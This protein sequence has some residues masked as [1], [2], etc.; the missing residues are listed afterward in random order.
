MG[1]ALHIVT[2]AL[3]RISMIV[4]CAIILSC[5]FG[6]EDALSSLFSESGS[7]LFVAMGGGG[8]E[9]VVLASQY[10][11]DWTGNLLNGM[12][13]V[14]LGVTVYGN[15]RFV[16]FSDGGTF[17]VSHD[18]L[19]W[20]NA[21]IDPIIR[22]NDVICH[23]GLF[24]AVGMRMP[25]GESAI[26]VSEDGLI[27]ARA[28]APAI[29]QPLRGI[30]YG[31]GKF[32]AV[33]DEIIT[34]SIDGLVWS[35]NL[36]PSGS[37]F[38]EDVAYGSG[39]FVVVGAGGMANVSVDGLVWSIPFYIDNACNG[40]GCQMSGITYDSGKFIAV[41][42]QFGMATIHASL[43]GLVWTPNLNPM[44]GPSLTRVTA[45]NGTFIAVSGTDQYAFSGTGYVWN[46][47]NFS[48]G[49]SI[50]GVA[51]RP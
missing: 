42:D 51:C 49:E 35:P 19:L 17:H 20:W 3:R 2:I 7:P 33:G 27:W 12:G 16:S 10:G 34:V 18:G 36:R 4:P 5:A 29:N 11:R 15:G 8:G 9:G 46:T 21:M 23:N 39:V 28:L 24:V 37:Y 32:V 43:E 45:C 14:T 22:I 1:K 6:D 50:Y 30:A 26:W 38:L 31:N 25:P 40:G 48:G 44:G 41:G 47:E 13:G